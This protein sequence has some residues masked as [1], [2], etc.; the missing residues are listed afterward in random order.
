MSRSLGAKTEVKMTQSLRQ[1]RVVLV[2]NGSPEDVQEKLD[3]IYRGIVTP[4]LNQ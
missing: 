3:K 1:T 4:T 2:F